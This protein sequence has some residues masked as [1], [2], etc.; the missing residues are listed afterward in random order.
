MLRY[1][2][3]PQETQAMQDII[4]SGQFFS[5]VFIKNDGTIRRASGKKKRY[6]SDSPETEK[7][8]KYNRLDRDLLLVWD[9]NKTYVDKKTGELVRG[10]YI[11]A[12]LPNILFF[13]NKD[14]TEENAAAIEAAGITPEQIEQERSRQ[15]VQEIV[16]EEV[17]LMENMFEYSY[18]IPQLIDIIIERTDKPEE[19]RNFFTHQFNDSL[20]KR[21]DQGVVDDFAAITGVQIEPITRGRYVFAQTGG[22]GQPQLEG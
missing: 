11:Q 20:K 4:N 9:T 21:G 15:R 16:Q 7:R 17:S 18:T 3:H 12:K 2:T 6:E 5:I 8:G 1:S 13:N 10:A 19:Y 14:F 22:G